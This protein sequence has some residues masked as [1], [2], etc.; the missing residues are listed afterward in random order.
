MCPS[1]TDCITYD[2]VDGICAPS[3]KPD[4][5]PVTT[6]EIVGDCKRN[7]C[8]GGKVIVQEDNTDLVPDMNECTIEECKAGV[9][10]N[11][12]ATDGTQCGNGL[13]CVG[14]ECSGCNKDPAKCP[15]PT[16]CQ[17]VTCPQDKCIYEILEGKVLDATAMDDCKQVVCNGLGDPETVAADNETPPQVGDN[18]KVE[19]C[20]GMMVVQQDSMDT[21]IC[22]PVAGNPCQTD[23][24]CI[25]AVCTPQYQPAGTYAGDNGNNKDCKG[26]YCDGMGNVMLGNDDT[27]KP[28][29]PDNKD[30]VVPKCMNG[31]MVNTNL[32]PGDAC[33]TVMN[34]KCCGANCCANTGTDYCDGMNMCCATGKAC[35]GTCCPN[36]ADECAGTMCCNKKVC[37]GTCC[38]TNTDCAANGAC[39]PANKQCGTQCC[40]AMENCVMNVCQ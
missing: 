3:I 6:G 33:T 34:G 14:G 37:N 39:C 29:D 10:I 24:I 26:N 38:P 15:A 4:G 8:S 36:A 20:S 11:S 40:G 32:M 16:Q 18:C 22:M 9:K 35:G 2:C 19:K 23:S 25:S 13:S 31:M 30:C 27:E 5:T 1:D 7:V 17:V 21:T 28:M 12:L